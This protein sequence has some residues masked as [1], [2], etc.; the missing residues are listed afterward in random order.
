[1]IH[2]ISNNAAS[3]LMEQGNLGRLSD[4][5]LIPA[6]T[7]LLLTGLM[8]TILFVKWVWSTGCVIV[9]ADT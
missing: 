7:L 9:R 4:M 6:V 2:N 8:G 3:E 5:R 1:L